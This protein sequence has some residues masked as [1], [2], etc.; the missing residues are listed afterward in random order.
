MDPT[1]VA[2][3]ISRSAEGT[4]VDHVLQALEPDSQKTAF[5]HYG[6]RISR[7]QARTMV[8]QMARALWNLGLGPDDSIAVLAA[9]PPEVV[10]LQLAVHLLGRRYV[11]VHPRVAISQQ[12]AFLGVARPTVLVFDPR[13]FSDRAQELASSCGVRHVLSFGPAPIGVDLLQLAANQREEP[14]DSPASADRISTVFYS[15]GTTGQ[16]KLVLHSHAGYAAMVAAHLFREATGQNTQDE[17]FLLCTPVTHGSGQLATLLTV[18]TGGTVILLDELDPMAVLDTIVRERV[19]TVFLTPPLLYQVLDLPELADA[20]ASSLTAITYGAAM[21]SPDRLAQAIARFG[22]ILR[23]VYGSTEAPMMSMLEPGAHDRPKRLSAAGRPVIGMEL[24]IRDEGDDELP[25]SKVGEICARGI[26]V[27]AGYL[28]Q[29]E[30]TARTMRHGWFHTGDLGYLDEEGFLYV[31]GRARDMIVTGISSDNVYPRTVEDVLVTHAGV[32]S[33]AVIGIPDAAQG[34]AIHAVV[35]P[36]DGWKPDAEEIRDFVGERLG[37]LYVPRSVDFVPALPLTVLGKV[38]KETLRL[39]ARS[40][41]T[42]PG[43]V[44]GEP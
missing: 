7:R 18:L 3:V 5:V 9:N 2:D 8:F 43:P 35:V 14:L 4:Y 30:L 16:P 31:V 28:G 44:G 23:Q 36:R 26:L 6:R 17:R 41:A 27:M 15:G 40:R 22:P 29:P 11:S 25:P 39:W 42:A 10:L 12:A 1:M 37:H 32:R 33:A 34:E 24:S 20:D 21:A 13:Y 38:D 19:T